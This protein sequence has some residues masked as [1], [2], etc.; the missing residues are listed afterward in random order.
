MLSVVITSVLNNVLSVM[1]LVPLIVMISRILNLDAKPYI[2]CMGII[3]NIG[4]LFFSVSQVVN[5]LISSYAG[6]T[7][8]EFFLNVGL[9]AIMLIVPTLFLFYF[10]YRKS[11]TPLE[12]GIEILKEFDTWSFIP[13]K[14]L[15]YKALFVLL[16]VMA[17]FV[18]IPSSIITPDIIALAGGV[19]LL[20]I[21]RLSIDEIIVKIDVQLVFYLLGIFTITGALNDLGVLNLIAGGLSFLGAGNQYL[22]VI[23]I[24]WIPGLLTGLTDPTSICKIMIPV[25]D[26]MSITLGLNEAQRKVAFF[27]LNKAIVLGDN[28]TAMGDNMIVVNLSHQYK[29][30]ITPKEITAVGMS[31]VLFQFFILTIYYAFVIEP[32]NNWV[33]GVALIAVTA[34]VIGVTFLVRY[35]IHKKLHVRIRD[36]LKRAKRP[37]FKMFR[38]PGKS[39][40]DVDTIEE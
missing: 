33:I 3:V 4:A 39:G 23:V 22:T 20:I 25:I 21:S 37:D 14:G 26:N 6:I 12:S 9:Q 36:M 13:N 27:A 7:F 11:W 32:W 8:G 30:P 38:K 35:I 31:T 5:I 19:L 29:R 10:F 24:M 15:M 40:T 28:L 18:I 17:C 2:L 1:I 16:G 34:G